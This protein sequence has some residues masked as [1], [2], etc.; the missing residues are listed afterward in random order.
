MTIVTQ[1]KANVFWKKKK[2]PNMDAIS[3]TV[4]TILVFLHRV[5]NR[6]PFLCLMAPSALTLNN[7]AS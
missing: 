6:F 2:N 4:S 5:N 3:C 1:F 7:V